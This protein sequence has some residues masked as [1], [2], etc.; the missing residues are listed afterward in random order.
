MISTR[1][2]NTSVNVDPAEF[3]KILR[4]HPYD[5][6]H[7][8]FDLAYGKGTQISG[9]FIEQ[10]MTSS[11]T[12]TPF[13]EEIEN[14]ATTYRIFSFSFK[15][16][17]AN[18][19]LLRIDGNPRSLKSFTRRLSDILQFGFSIAVIHT[20][21]RSVLAI[22]N[23]GALKIVQITSL[24][25]SNVTVGSKCLGKLEVRKVGNGDALEAFE[26]VFPESSSVVDRFSAKVRADDINYEV[27]FTRLGGLGFDEGIE[28]IILA[29]YEEY[30]QT[31][32]S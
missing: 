27:Y 11:W 7:A 28:T 29:Q 5:G 8:G 12:I 21:V 18:N 2:Y 25:A 1:W 9:R 24:C 19:W 26:E 13:G 22:L 23:S 17:R 20:P 31:L 15:H 4:L 10:V 32:I 16:R 14:I 3:L 6:D 30:L